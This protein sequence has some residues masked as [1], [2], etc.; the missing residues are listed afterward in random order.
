VFCWSGANCLLYPPQQ[1]MRLRHISQER[2]ARTA[3][4]ASCI[5]SSSSTPRSKR[6]MDS[7]SFE[8]SCCCSAVRAAIAYALAKAARKAESWDIKN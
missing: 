8:S 5:L 7:T 2:K 1:P 3:A 4:Y 6:L